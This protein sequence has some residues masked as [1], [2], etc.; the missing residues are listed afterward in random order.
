M[1]CATRRIARRA[2]WHAAGHRLSAKEA[3]ALEVGDRGRVL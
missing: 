3:H 1:L 2:T